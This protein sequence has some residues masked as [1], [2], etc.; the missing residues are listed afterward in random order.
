MFKRRG[1]T[2]A[3]VIGFVIGLFV[4]VVI[5]IVVGVVINDNER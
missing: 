3:G 2:N 5:G 1:K 4:G